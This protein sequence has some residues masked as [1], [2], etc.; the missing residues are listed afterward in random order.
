MVAEPMRGA[1]RKDLEGEIGRVR[2]AITRKAGRF[3]PYIQLGEGK[4]AKRSSI[5]KDIPGLDLDWAKGALDER[6]TGDASDN[7]SDSC[8]RGRWFGIFVGGIESHAV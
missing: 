1:E 8:Q 3:G 4:E 7:D 2:E 5:P 6:W